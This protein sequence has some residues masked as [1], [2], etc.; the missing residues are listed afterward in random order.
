[1]ASTPKAQ[2]LPV[3]TIPRTDTSNPCFDL[4]ANDEKNWSSPHVSVPLFGRKLQSNTP[5]IGS[6]GC[7]RKRKTVRLNQT[8]RNAFWKWRRRSQIA[9][10]VC[11]VERAEAS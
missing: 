3:A 7:R 11:F 5:M 8:H 1:M 10:N 6:F 4:P 9:R 2:L